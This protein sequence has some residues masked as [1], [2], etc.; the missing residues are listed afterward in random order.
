MDD[1]KKL[2]IESV[3]KK[4]RD[5]MY[6]RSEQL[7]DLTTYQKETGKIFLPVSFVS[8]LFNYLL[9]NFVICF[10]NQGHEKLRIVRTI[11]ETIRTLQPKVKLSCGL[12]NFVA[13]FP[14]AT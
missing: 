7:Y 1:I 8:K 12:L 11:I 14:F 10:E 3:D 6:F 2:Q 9:V 13:R 4:V 5:D